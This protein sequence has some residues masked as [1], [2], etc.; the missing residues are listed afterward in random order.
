MGSPKGIRGKQAELQLLATRGPG[1]GL[2]PTD[3]FSVNDFTVDPRLTED[4]HEHLGNPAGIPDNDIKG[5]GGAFKV[6]VSNFE[7]FDLEDKIAQQQYNNLEDFDIRIIEGPYQKP[8][9]ET[10]TRSH[11]GVVLKFGR[12]W[13][14]RSG[15]IMHTIG[16]RSEGIPTVTRG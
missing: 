6:E 3:V 16:W 11:G 4:E 13:P 9:G 7:T 12:S 5:Y 15:F 10:Y 1:T 2:Q 14:S 8:N